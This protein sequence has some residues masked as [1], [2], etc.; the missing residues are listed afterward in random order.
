MTTPGETVKGG[1]DEITEVVEAAKEEVKKEVETKITEAE[2]RNL[3][4]E[5]KEELER[6][7]SVAEEIIE[8][9]SISKGRIPGYKNEEKK[10]VLYVVTKTV[11]L[12]RQGLQ[13]GIDYSSYISKSREGAAVLRNIAKAPIEFT[14]STA[15]AI[16]YYFLDYLVGNKPILISSSSSKKSDFEVDFEN[17]AK[18]NKLAARI[19][20]EALEKG[21][22]EGEINSINNDQIEKLRNYLLSISSESNPTER[23]ISKK[24]MDSFVH[25]WRRVN[26]AIAEKVRSKTVTEEQQREFNQILFS[27]DPSVAL[28]LLQQLGLSPAE[29][30]EFLRLKPSYYGELNTQF[31]EGYLPRLAPIVHEAQREFNELFAQIMKRNETGQLIMS[32]EERKKLKDMIRKYLYYGLKEI[33]SN[34]STDFHQALQERSDVGHYFS[35]IHQIIGYNCERI[36]E[37]IAPNTKEG[38]ELR[39]FLTDMGSSFISRNLTF[40]QIFH[41]LP[42]YVRNLNDIEQLSKMFAYIYPSQLAEIFDDEGSLMTIARDELTMLIREYLVRNNNM[43]GG[44]FLSGS[45]KEEGC[46]WSDKFRADFIRRLREKLQRVT[47]GLSEEDEWKISMFTTYAEGIGIATLIDGEIL[48]TSRPVSHFRDVH[49]LM[50]LLSAKHNWYGG[51][52]GDAIG[53]INRFLLGMD[54]SLIPQERP[55]LTRLIT[56]RRFDPKRFKEMIDKKVKFYGGV[57]SDEMVKAAVKSFLFDMGG[58][59]QEL[60]SMLSLPGDIASWGGWRVDGITNELKSIFYIL[61]EKDLTDAWKSWNDDNW[62]EFFDLS[63]ELYGTTSLWWQIGVSGGGVRVTQEIRRFFL[64]LCK[65]DMEKAEAMFKQLSEGKG[66]LEK[67]ISYPGIN[68]KISFFE[69]K[70]YKLNQLRAEIFFRFLR[71]NP[72]EF[73]AVLSQLVPEIL[74][75]KTLIFKSE[76][77][78]KQELKNK[79]KTK[80]EIEEILAQRAA[81]ESRFGKEIFALFSQTHQW[82]GESMA[83]INNPNT[84]KPFTSRKD[85]FSY[86]LERTSDAFERLKIANEPWRKEIIRVANDSTLS[87]DEKK[88]K[89]NEIRKKMIY[90]RREDFGDDIEIWKAFA[91]ENGFFKLITG[92]SYDNADSF[93]NNNLGGYNRAC[94][95]N[96]FYKMAEVWFIRNDDINPFSSDMSYYDIFKHI[97]LSG[98]NTLKRI[99]DADLS[100]Y[101][102]V[103]SQIPNLETLLLE[104]AQT[105]DMKKIYELHHK[106]Y[107][108]LSGFVS[109]EYAQRANYLLSQIVIQFFMEHSVLRDP[110]FNYLGPVKLLMRAFIGENRSLSRLLTKNPH[111]YSMDSN[112]IRDYLMKL[113]QF[114]P[115]GLPVIAV[116]GIY[117]KEQLEKVFEVTQGE[118]ILGDVFPK[119]AWFI[120]IFLIWSYMKKAMEEAEGKKK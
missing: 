113:S 75:D 48:T 22:R 97:S 19:I 82:L 42:L 25:L 96:L 62:R 90:L 98:E 33:H 10:R 4:E 76:E 88:Q 84:G 112:A 101:K 45:Y 70:N 64:D 35:L 63:L 9:E 2:R 68:E 67:V 117:S 92:V 44:D 17:L 118:F 87:A 102:E 18:T 110:I 57:V 46:Y 12:V 51:R 37:L 52:G 116:D 7:K 106:V 11:E 21:I 94:S 13:R 32:K 95:E 31:I 71:R 80:A 83:R 30:Q 15:A 61:Y 5:T 115:E 54:V 77:E 81:L 53:L 119:L 56:K 40:A 93:F 55:F 39:D 28:P 60:I 89:I 78:I 41:N 114:G 58:R 27:K 23:F 20:I 86:F 8:G 3:G 6:V 66:A 34:R 120:I 100:T 14:P 69:L 105:G 107:K 109:P 24:E 26:E 43:Y 74:D 1:V 16:E 85:F 104:V 50:Q 49:P 29:S 103:I 38:R 72:G 65:G 91:G 59:Y 73:L 99:A 108:T 47:G 111:A 36:A 79:R